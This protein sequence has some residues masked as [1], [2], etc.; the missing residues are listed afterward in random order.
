MDIKLI[1]KEEINKS[2]HYDNILETKYYLKKV[3]NNLLLINENEDESEWT[4]DEPSPTYH[5]D[6]T[7]K[8]KEDLKK[9]RR[10]VK[11]KDDVIKYIK[12]LLEEIKDLPSNFKKRVVK[13]IFYSFIGILSLSEINY[14]YNNF[15]SEIEKTTPIEK[16]EKIKKD[17]VEKIRKP[18]EELFT[19]LKKKEG[20]KGK[21][22]LYFYDIGDGAYTTGYGHAVFSNSKKGST[23]GDYS[24]VP[25]YEDI[26]LFD[27]DNPE[28]E[29]TTIT[30]AQA[31][32]L[33]YDDMLKASKGVNK[34]LDDWELE[35][36]KPRVTQGMYNAMVS[37][38][39]NY[40]VNNLRMSDFIQYVK[41][42]ELE[43]AKEEI[44]N[45]SSNLF[46]EYPGLKKRRE[47]ESK[48]FKLPK[49]F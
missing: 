6:L 40:G 33:L 11:T 7:Q 20:I 32:K 16:T 44:K 10:W 42:G 12:T 38:A 18:S 23:G 41:R 47:E 27:K 5:W 8:V 1:I 13:Y 48:M 22:V 34:I 15:S 3:V 35:D 31:E 45:I 2:I 9:S 17:V 29:H 24:F 28:K 43:K 36:I 4:K 25:N 39:Y 37:I 14:L 46:D 21:P 19:H 30:S 26:I 49:E